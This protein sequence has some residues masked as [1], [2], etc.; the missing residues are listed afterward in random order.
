M[1]AANHPAYKEELERCR[2][3][4]DY[5]ERSLK[6][7]LEKREKIGNELESVQKHLSGDSSA[8]YTS[9]L[10][11][12]MLHD[13]LALKIKNL[14]TARGKPYFARVD[15]RENNSDRTEKLYIGKMSLSRK[16]TRR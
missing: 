12:T 14:Y 7:A 15:Y 9:I 2:Y 13:T 6:K 11:N 4:L 5:V 16:K 10:V 3:T 8:D 1:S